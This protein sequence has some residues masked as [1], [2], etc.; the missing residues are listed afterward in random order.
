MSGVTMR[1]RPSSRLAR[2]AALAF[3]AVIAFATLWPLPDQ[4]QTNEQLCVIC[5][6]LGGIDFLS[7]IVLFL[8]LGIALGAAGVRVSRALLL[9]AGFS[10]GIEILQWQVVAGRDASL[11]DLVSNTMGAVVGALAVTSHRVLLYPSPRMARRLA[12]AMTVVLVVAASVGA[13]ALRPAPVFWK[14]WSQWAP[15]R[16]GFES[17][18]GELLAL[19]LNDRPIPIGS[20]I[21]P[22]RETATFSEGIF[23]VDAR[24]VPDSSSPG[25]LLIARAGNPIDEEFELVQRGRDLLFRARRNAARLS[26]RSP[27]VALPG[28]FGGRP[29]G[30]V[31]I[32]AYAGVA[33]IELVAGNAAGVITADSIPL[34]LGRTWQV[35]FP[36]DIRDPSLHGPGA[37]AFLTVAI[38]P[39]AYWAGLGVIGS[40]TLVW[41]GSVA[42][43]LLGG[44]PMLAGIAVG[45]PWDA[46]GLT[47][48]SAI[49]LAL[50]RVSAAR[51][52]GS[53]GRRLPT[54]TLL[55]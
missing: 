19:T 1:H 21:D 27:V 8:P 42:L 14:Y 44:L 18:G 30:P 20:V 35:I 38:L 36:L 13:W 41:L 48:G 34:T 40:A 45:G 15:T 39:L 50:A 7:N 51:T 43:L 23:Q 5:G 26:L 24:L 2:L 25:A 31:E 55:R 6:A 37:M 29:V 52:S 54:G 17:F 16:H 28:A 49:G 9:G 33:R 10:L 53:G 46:A 47:L 4:P 22:T 11:G 12:S 3:A 32:S